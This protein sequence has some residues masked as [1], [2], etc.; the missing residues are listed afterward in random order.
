MVDF[1]WGFVPLP[2]LRTVG[3]PLWLS[4]G[5]KPWPH[6]NRWFTELKNGGSFYMANCECHNRL[7]V[8]NSMVMFH[9]YVSHNQRLLYTSLVDSQ[10]PS[11]S[12][13][14]PGW[15]A[16]SKWP[17]TAAVC[18]QSSTSSGKTRRTIEPP[19]VWN[20]VPV[21]HTL[22]A[23]VAIITIYIYIYIYIWPY[24]AIY[25]Y[26]NIELTIRLTVLL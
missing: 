11:A 23:D 2:P 14:C 12:P 18:G 24:I 22:R 10:A 6:R 8:L 25:N 21:H 13:H 4:H 3:V 5:K 15:V 7:T 26:I 1:P 16:T 20:W 9:G 17:A 19:A